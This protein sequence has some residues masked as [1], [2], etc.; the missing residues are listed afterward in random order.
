MKKKIIIWTIVVIVYGLSAWHMRSWMSIAL[1]DEGRWSSQDAD[2]TMVIMTYAPLVNTIAVT[3]CLDSP[4]RDG[5][6]G[7]TYNKLIGVKK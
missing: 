1:G 3:C 7:N 4:Y 2:L 6:G 5:R